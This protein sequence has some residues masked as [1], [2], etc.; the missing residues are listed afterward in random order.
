[1]RCPPRT[2]RAAITNVNRYLRRTT[3]LTLFIDHVPPS[4]ANGHNMRIGGD[5]C[6]PWIWCVNCGAYSNK[7]VNKLAEQCKGNGN[8]FA[9]N[10]LMQGYNPCTSKEMRAA[11][12]H[13]PDDVHTLAYYFQNPATI[14]GDKSRVLSGAVNAHKTKDKRLGNKWQS[15]MQRANIRIAPHLR[16]CNPS[17]TMMKTAQRERLPHTTDHNWQMHLAG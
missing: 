16:Y 3:D 17:N 14:E 1:M 9:V 2:S 6:N 8:M 7:V 10:T 5:S 13:A 11:K 4:A 15:I 12:Q